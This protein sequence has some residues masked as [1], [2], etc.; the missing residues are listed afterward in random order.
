MR[1]VDV[2]RVFSSLFYWHLYFLITFLLKS[3][4]SLASFRFSVEISTFSSLSYWNLYFLSTLVYWNPIFTALHC[5]KQPCLASTQSRFYC[6]TQHFGADVGAKVR[7][8]ASPIV[9]T[10]SIRACTT[11]APALQRRLTPKPRLTP[12]SFVKYGCHLRRAILLFY[13]YSHLIYGSPRLHSYRISLISRG[14]HISVIS[15]RIDISS[16]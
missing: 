3:R 12:V 14:H 8:R 2:F 1:E 15:L 11:S 4:L 6:K 9:T 16:L 7:W 13:F 5:E 10:I